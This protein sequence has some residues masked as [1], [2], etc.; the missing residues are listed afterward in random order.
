M[1]DLQCPRRHGAALEVK[2]G[3]YCPCVRF[4]APDGSRISQYDWTAQSGAFAANNLVE[5][6]RR[7]PERI[8]KMR[9]RGMHPEGT[10][11][12]RGSIGDPETPQG[13]SPS[14]D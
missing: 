7:F 8:A 2:D 4:Q 13:I 6:E 9:L 3:L 1:P 12:C 11:P 14:G 5:L 10:N